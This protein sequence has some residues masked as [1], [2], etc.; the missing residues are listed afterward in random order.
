MQQPP[1]TSTQPTSALSDA[2]TL[3]SGATLGPIWSTPLPL[4][5]AA[6][7]FSPKRWAAA[8]MSSTLQ[9]VMTLASS[10]LRAHAAWENS[11]KP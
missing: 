8:R 10:R 6:G 2:S 1:C 9:P 7:V 3:C 5:R 4:M 11:S